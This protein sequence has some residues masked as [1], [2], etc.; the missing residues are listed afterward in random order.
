MLDQNTWQWKYRNEERPNYD[1]R[2]LGKDEK[3]PEL[4][5][6]DEI[7]KKPSKDEFDRKMKELDERANQKRALIEEL[8]L[9]RKLVYEGGKVEG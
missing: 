9:K 7:K 3:I 8:R 1:N 6:G 4:P 2:V 5:T